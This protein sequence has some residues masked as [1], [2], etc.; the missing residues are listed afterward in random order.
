MKFLFFNNTPAHVHLYRNAVKQLRDEGH[1]VT[2]LARD[3]GCTIDLLEY[4]NLPYEIYGSRGASKSSLV[5]QLPTQFYTITKLVR[6][7]N[8]DLI[9]GVGLYAA[10]AGTVTRTPTVNFCDTD[11]SSFDQPI[12]SRLVTAVLS[13]YP[14]TKDLPGTHIRFN[15]LNELAYLHP[16][17]FESSEGVRE[18]L[19]ISQGEPYVVV[20]FNVF[21]S[22]HDV[23]DQ[24][25]SPDEKERLVK[26]LSRRAEVIVSDEYYERTGDQTNLHTY[27]LHPARLHDV[28]AEAELVIA[29]TGTVI[30]EAALMGTPAIRLR[31]NNFDDQNDLGNFLELERQGLIHNVNSS[32]KVLTRATSILDGSSYNIDNEAYLDERIN[33]TKMIVD[34]ARELPVEGDLGAILDEYQ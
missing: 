2:I 23:G 11:R 15:G 27:D 5:T 14:F 7:Y 1:A 13:P 22:T 19:G 29:D 3:N 17:C 33:P 12:S 6:R 25:F 18:E 10:F 31:T 26:E 9:F 20:R 24:G 34:L 4:Y 8:P 30:T 32:K 21:G 28:I 16:D